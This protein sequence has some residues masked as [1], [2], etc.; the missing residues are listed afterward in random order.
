VFETPEESRQAAPLV[1]ACSDFDN[2]PSFQDANA[3]AV[4]RGWPILFAVLGPPCPRIGP[5]VVPGAGPCLACASQA[6]LPP[7]LRA[8]E[9]RGPDVPAPAALVLQRV[10]EFLRTPPDLVPQLGGPAPSGS[11]RRCALCGWTAPR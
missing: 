9:H 5:L 8:G 6:P 2:P 10:R 1:V 7:L 4:S 11:G 3:R